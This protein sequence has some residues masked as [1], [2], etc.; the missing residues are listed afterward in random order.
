[1]LTVKCVD[2]QDGFRSLREQWNS[3]AA[4]G[5][6]IFQTWEWCWT[7]WSRYGRGRKLFILCAYDD[8]HLVGLAPLFISTYFGLP[9]RVAG[10]LG[11]GC[12]DYGD[13]LLAP[14]HADAALASLISYVKNDRRWDVLDLQ[15]L[16]PGSSVIGLGK[17]VDNL[18]V[19]LFQ[20]DECFFRSLPSAYDEFL[21]SL[22]KKFR[23]NVKYYRRRLEREGR[24]EFRRSANP[25]E[26]RN[27][28]RTFFRLHQKRFIRKLKPGRFLIPRFLNFHGDVAASLLDAGEL[29]LFF[30]MMDGRAVASLY[31]FKLGKTFYY[32]LAGFEPGWGQYSVSTVL[33]AHV[34]EECIQEGVTTFDFLRG[35]EPYKLRWGAVGELNM[36]VVVGRSTQRSQ[37]ARRLIQTENKVVVKT[38]ARL[39]EA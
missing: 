36:R 39:A 13:I 2:T 33:L 1:M 32:Y 9:L 18:H 12:S 20:Q 27:D 22:S 21:G 3:L 23:W 10:F 7:W 4:S 35:A 6:S 37:I 31:G 34:F 25:N 24:L 8:D 16:P 15:Q 30:L 28:V 26:V 19:G 29:R 38:K 17:L 5:G 14:S 11:T